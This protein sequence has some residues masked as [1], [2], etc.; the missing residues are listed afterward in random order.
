MNWSETMFKLDN[1]LDLEL[2][3]FISIA[4]DNQQD[5]KKKTRFYTVPIDEI[6]PEHTIS[7]I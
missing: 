3:S 1:L 5:E 6:L 2:P 4:H 7:A